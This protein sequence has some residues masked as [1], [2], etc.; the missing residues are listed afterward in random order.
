VAGIGKLAAKNIVQY[1]TKNGSFTNKNE[2]LN[3]SMFGPKTF[4]QCAGFLR[5]PD[6]ENPLDNSAIHH[7]SYPINRKNGI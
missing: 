6:G 1:R 2:L 5:I 3:V 7:E 4:T